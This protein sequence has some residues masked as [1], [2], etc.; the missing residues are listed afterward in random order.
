MVGVLLLIGGVIGCSEDKVTDPHT[1][2]IRPSDRVL[3]FV[4][5]EGF[6]PIESIHQVMDWND[7]EVFRVSYGEGLDC[8]S[9]C[10]Y[11]MAVGMHYGD[12]AGW[13]G[14]EDFH[15]HQP[16]SSRFFDF[17]E[18]DTLLF[19]A[20]TWFTMM[21]ESWSACFD[22][23]LPALAHDEQTSR[24]ALLMLSTLIYSHES[25][26]IAE[27]LVANPTVM[28]DAEILG[29]LAGLPVIRWDVYAEVRSRAQE[30]LDDFSAGPRQDR[31]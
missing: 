5:Q 27:Y 19:D 17:L 1:R 23:L 3:D 11:S 12:R 28:S 9:G 6:S 22:M 21:L 13:L 7:M 25:L 4:A 24:N 16:D 30:L 8:P 10:F 26:E 18:T 29:I 20:D 2:I 31:P 14:F 15:E